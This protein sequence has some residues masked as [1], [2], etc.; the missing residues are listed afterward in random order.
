[1]LKRCRMR[2]VLTILITLLCVPGPSQALAQ[3]VTPD[4]ISGIAVIGDSLSDGGRDS[5]YDSTW[6]EFLAARR[7]LDFGPDAGGRRRSF[8]VAV[9]GAQSPDILQPNLHRGAASQ[10][11][12]VKQFVRNG[13]VDVVIFLIGHNDINHTNVLTNAA[14]GGL[15]PAD[16]Q[17]IAAVVQH[18]RSAWQIVLSGTGHN[19]DLTPPRVIDPPKLI[20]VG[21]ADMTQTPAFRQM[22][23]QHPSYNEQSVHRVR[24]VV[25][26]IN[27]ALRRFAL[28]ENH[29]TFVEFPP[30]Q[31]H[32]N[33]L[34]DFRIGGVEIANLDE[35][36]TD[37]TYLFKDGI[38]PRA[39]G[40]GLI[41]NL[42]L[43]GINK[44]TGMNLPM[45][46]DRE[47]LLSA[48]IGDRFQRV[49]FA[50][51]IYFGTYTTVYEGP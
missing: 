46:T 43:F 3:L 19:P 41:S 47:I 28:N 2:L 45:L 4:D 16:H 49:T 22:V 15:T 8:N 29:A 23:A 18:V 13:E 33:A 14:L 26:T 17:R 20:V 12:Q 34:T 31:D 11:E 40:N 21:I 30:F 37:P 50:Q 7:D 9:S 51:Q 5:A 6:V 39:V 25:N 1:M 10:A 48:G 38:H 35:S 44:T 24:N 42:V 36:P 27:D 32:I